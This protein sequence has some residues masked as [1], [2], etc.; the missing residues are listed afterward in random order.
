MVELCLATAIK[1]DPANLA[2]HVYRNGYNPDHAAAV[3]AF[4]ARTN[5][6][7]QVTSTLGSLQSASL[8]SASALSPCSPGVQW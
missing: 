3:A 1:R 6:Y 7:S 8:Q 2:L 5:A 4:H